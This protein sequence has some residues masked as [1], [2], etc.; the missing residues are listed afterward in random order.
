MNVL[1]MVVK[2]GAAGLGIAVGALAV[3]GAFVK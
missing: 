2:I 3:R 1:S